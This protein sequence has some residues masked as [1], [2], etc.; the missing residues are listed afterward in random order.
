MI[1]K[2]PLPLPLPLVVVT[3]KVELNHHFIWD[4]HPAIAPL[5]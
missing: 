4:E 2:Y 1:L 3:R 5:K